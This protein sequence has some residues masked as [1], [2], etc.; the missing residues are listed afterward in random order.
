MF[1]NFDQV[2]PFF[3]GNMPLQHGHFLLCFHHSAIHLLWKLCL[4]EGI[5]NK[6]PCSS[7]I[8]SKQITHDMSTSLVGNGSSFFAS[9]LVRA[10]HIELGCL[11][12]GVGRTIIK[13][14]ILCKRQVFSK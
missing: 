2:R 3:S 12:S 4:H 6:F 13:M 10:V 5:V 7:S 8:T 9:A 11:I 14:F 1:C